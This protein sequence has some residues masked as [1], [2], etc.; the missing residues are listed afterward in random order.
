M[1]SKICL[2]YFNLIA[3]AI[4]QV[5][6]Y[7][8]N[9]IDVGVLGS[10]SLEQHESRERNSFYFNKMRSLNTTKSLYKLPKQCLLVDLPNPD[11]MLSSSCAISHN[12]LQNVS[13]LTVLVSRMVT[14]GVLYRNYVILIFLDVPYS[15]PNRQSTR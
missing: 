13:F 11:K 2:F 14:N 15:K 3:Q 4:N 5:F 12:E 10:H 9:V 8:R 6:S 1:L 7:S